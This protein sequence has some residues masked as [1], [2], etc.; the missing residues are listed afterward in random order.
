MKALLRVQPSKSEG[1]ALVKDPYMAQ[2]L[3][4][5]LEGH[6]GEQTNARLLREEGR[7]R[8]ATDARRGR[9][10]FH[11]RRGWLLG[12]RE[13]RQGFYHEDASSPGGCRGPTGQMTSE[14][15]TGTLQGGG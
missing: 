5:H 1:L 8:G 3:T 6:S 7:S 9:A 13:E 10:G 12:W 15:L 14:V 4:Q 2:Q 11:F